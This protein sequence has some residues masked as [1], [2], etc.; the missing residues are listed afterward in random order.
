MKLYAHPTLEELESRLAPDATT[1]VAWPDPTHLTLSFVPDG[2][3]ID[4]QGSVLFGMLNSQAP[5]AVWQ[6]EILRAVQSWADL[7]NID[8]SVVPDGGQPLGATGALEGD[9]RFGDIRIGARPMPT[10]DF[11]TGSPFQ[12]TGTTWSGD[13][14]LNSNYA[15]SLGGATGYDLF[16]VALHEAGH[17]LGMMHVPSPDSPMYGVYDG[18]KA[19]PTAQDALNLQTLYG[20]RTGEPSNDNTMAG[21]T[22]LATGA[23][24][25]DGDIGATGDVD[26]YKFLVPAGAAPES[27]AITL[28]T[29][30]ISSLV[31]GLTIY[32]SAGVVVATAAATDP[33]NGNVT[34]QVNGAA[35]LSTYYVR[36]AGNSADA[37]GV[38]AYHLSLAFSTLT[39]QIIPPLA[40]P[41]TFVNDLHT[42]DS[43]GT[44]TVLPLRWGPTQDARFQYVYAAQISDGSD[45]DYY[46]V[47]A[48]IVGGGT[49]VMV[50]MVWAMDPSNPLAPRIDVF[51][52]LGHTVAA[53]VIANGNG[54]F[55]V[56]LTNVPSGAL[57]DIKVSALNSSG[58]G[59]TG[60]YIAA[61]NFH[62]GPAL[63]FQNAADGTLAD[64][65][66]VTGQLTLNQSGLVDFRLS[67]NTTAGNTG[68]Q[69]TM[70]IR[71]AQGNV[72][73]SLT[74]TDGQSA[75]TAS[76]YLTSGQY[77]VSFT[78]T[79][80][81]GGALA[82]PIDYGLDL[83]FLSDPM[84][85]YPNG[86][87]SGSGNT[88][89]YV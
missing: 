13:I 22:W 4:G 60:N 48:P 81:N 67:A 52:A 37:F 10:D 82:F 9:S 20:A 17:A 11:G 50:A 24:Q 79:A 19:G 34:V 21:A 27:F 38:G 71:D 62:A 89:K 18:L 68:E 45:V 87:Q 39:G 44:A 30:H 63:A 66:T 57:Y 5:T 70:T 76:A 25:A 88:Y 73:L 1:G 40:S 15:F 74:A 31:G 7:A 47:Q 86:D 29:S 2:T 16:T 32:N 54:T 51:D 26:F 61:M 12:W 23:A 78:A 36:V 80:P 41:F 3:S 43:I 75:V 49:Q 46:Q 42:N 84:G 69:V 85:T 6:R 14:V 77:T 8:V 55:T 72:V 83:L 59:S 35:P 33:F 64:S 56:Q 65:Q 58:S 53:E 28:Q